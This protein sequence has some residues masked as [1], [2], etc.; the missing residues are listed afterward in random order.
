MSSPRG[1]STP[2]QVLGLLLVG[3]FLAACAPALPEPPPPPLRTTPEVSRPPV[4]EQNCTNGTQSYEPG[5]LPAP[6]KLPADS[7]MAAIKKRGRLIAGVSADTYLL[8]AR[9]PATGTIEGFDIDFVR[10]ISKAIFGKPDQYELKVIT[11][12]DR[13]PVLQDKEVDIVVRAFTMN[14]ER[15]DQVAFSSVYYEAGQKVLVRA[16]SGLKTL[17]DLAGRT[18]CAPNGTSSITNFERQ[19]PDAEIVAAIDHTGCL[20][21]F[22]K[23]EVDAITGD[24][25]VLAGLAAQDP[26]AEIL[27]GEPFSSEP[28]GVG[29]NADQ[30]DLVK[31]INA[32]LDQMRDNGEW[33]DSYD[34][35]LKPALGQDTP[36]EAEYGR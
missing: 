35:W 30:V 9:N 27:D 19:V 2:I 20:V 13:I 7:T 11:A 17:A 32:K 25:T 8:G 1:R 28:Y 18:V 26:Y 3:L 36:P 4:A 29:V 5:K 21:R 33:Q 6:D 24:D 34:R 10:A 14:C 16:G 23:G 31:F 22:Q 12:A 15:W